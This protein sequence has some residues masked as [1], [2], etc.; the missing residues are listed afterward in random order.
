[1][2]AKNHCPGK[3]VYWAKNSPVSSVP[4]DFTAHDWL[5]IPVQVNGRKIDAVISPTSECI[6]VNPHHAMQNFGVD[7]P[8]SDLPPF[9]DDLPNLLPHGRSTSPVAVGIKNVSI[10][11]VTFLNPA[12]RVFDCD[13]V[14]WSLEKIACPQLPPFAPGVSEL[15]K[16]RI[17]LDF[18][19]RQLFATTA[20]AS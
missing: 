4:L 9:G 14:G 12:T 13:D 16:L 5:R 10:D 18:Q 15:E 17:Y 2:F 6:Y 11:G 20:Q 3:V 19:D 7:I 8:A 1:M